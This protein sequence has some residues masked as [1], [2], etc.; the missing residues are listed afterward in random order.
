MSWGRV[1]CGCCDAAGAEGAAGSWV[2]RG[3]RTVRAYGARTARCCGRCGAG[4]L[5]GGRRGGFAGAECRDAVGAAG[6]GVRRARTARGCGRGGTG[7]LWGGGRGG[8]AG[9]SC[10]DPVGAARRRVRRARTARAYSSRTLQGRRPHVTRACRCNQPGLP[11]RNRPTT[12]GMPQTW[13]RI[14]F[15]TQLS[16]AL[17]RPDRELP[18]RWGARISV[19]ERRPQNC[20]QIELLIQ[21]SRKRGKHG[22][23][24]PACAPLC[25][26]STSGLA[27]SDAPAAP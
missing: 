14:L 22:A 6:L 24:S 3:A 5:W 25:T 18:G 9:S 8:I 19:V 20:V 2:H 1:H 13:M 27:L 23:G 26:A 16:V 11:G 10:W 15:C 17:N 4:A 7:A 21:Q 12:R